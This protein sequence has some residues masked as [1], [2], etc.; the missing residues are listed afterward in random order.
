M[1]LVT[2]AA[3][4]S[5]TGLPPSALVRAFTGVS[6]HAHTKEALDALIAELPAS[7]SRSSPC[8]WS[9]TALPSRTTGTRLAA[10]SWYRVE[11]ET[12]K[13][14]AARVTVSRSGPSG[15]AGAGRR[16][17]RD[18]PGRRVDREQG[19]AA[20]VRDGGS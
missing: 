16:L 3:Q 13:S 15:T 17:H 18:R 19:V 9:R 5:P 14:A 20:G 7:A 10:T 8:R 11:R 6:L 12:P 4:S 1:Q 2:T